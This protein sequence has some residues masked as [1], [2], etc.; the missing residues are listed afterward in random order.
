MR[1]T[2]SLEIFWGPASNGKLPSRFCASTEHGFS[3]LRLRPPVIQGKPRISKKHSVHE[4]AVVLHEMACTAARSDCSDYDNCWVANHNKQPLSEE[5]L[6][7]RELFSRESARSIS[8]QRLE[9][10]NSLPQVDT[11]ATWT[12]VYSGI[13]T[14][15]HRLIQN[16]SCKQQG[17]LQHHPA[18]QVGQITLPRL[19]TSFL[20]C[21]KTTY[22]C[23][24]AQ[25]GLIWPP[26]L[27]WIG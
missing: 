6:Y 3:P 9:N 26:A 22:V 11:S 4:I 21:Y 20:G 27:Q 7:A 10:Y 18:I 17:H 23:G 1:A 15:P 13:M 14:G 16:Q 2:R 25:H 8:C 12:G 24:P 19:D 5:G